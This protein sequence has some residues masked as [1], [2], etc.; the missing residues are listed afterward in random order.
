MIESIVTLV[1]LGV[2]GFYS[3]VA[4]KQV[5]SRKGVGAGRY[6]RK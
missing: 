2:V 6:G 1:I 4:G 5:G 3:Y